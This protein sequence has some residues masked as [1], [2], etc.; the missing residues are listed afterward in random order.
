MKKN[1]K[2]LIVRIIIGVVIV[3]LIAGFAVYKKKSKNKIVP[4]FGEVKRQTIIN[5]VSC[6]GVITPVTTVEIK[7][8]VGGTIVKLHADEGDFV[9]AG[10]L[11]AEID[12]VDVLTNLEKERNSLESAKARLSSAENNLEI[13]KKTVAADLVSAQEAV[14]SAESKLEQAKK[15]ASVQPALTNNEIANAKASLDSAKADLAQLKT[16][17]SATRRASAKSSYD[18][19]KASFEQVEKKYTR[20]KGLLEKGY[21]SRQDYDSIEQDYLSAKASYE[22]AKVAYDE[23]ANQLAEDIR[24]AE[25]KVSQ[26]QAS[27]DTA[28]KNKIQIDIK[29]ENVKTA[30]ASLR[31]AKANLASA[32]A[33][34]RNVNVRRS[35]VVDA[36]ATVSSA[37]SSVYNAETTYNYTRITAPRSGIITKKWTEEGSII[38]AGK[39]STAGSSQ[40]V[41]I[42]E[43]ADTT[44]MMVSVDVDETDISQISMGMHVDISVDAFPKARFTGNVTRIAAS[45]ET[46]SGVTTVPV[47]VTINETNTQIKPEMNA[48]C[49]FI[50]QRRDNV[51]ALPEDFIQTNFDGSTA[52]MIMKNKKPVPQKVELGIFGEDMVEI[53][54]GVTEGQQVISPK[55]LEVQKMPSRGMGRPP[56]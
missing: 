23:I 31:Q 32:R 46:D 2:K 28:V 5:S 50:V 18:S 25:N 26:A 16:S 17:S 34:L 12:P 6:D 9:K 4:V 42:F 48:S 24:V 40:G 41:V 1:R 53:N 35:D 11:L 30:E 45:A 22:N 56:F 39:A 7:S 21:I 10:Q 55:S 8:N 54:S 36:K 44:K 33:N 20:N 19:A 15:E 37:E 27:Y 13:S 49:E 38:M 3:A 51:L 43:I 29:N 52:V 47:E 14:R